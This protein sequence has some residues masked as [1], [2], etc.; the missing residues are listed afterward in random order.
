METRKR[1]V[2]WVLESGAF[3]ERP[4][5]MREAVLRAGDRWLEWQDEWLESGDWPPLRDGPVV[6]RGSLGNADV[7]R[8]RLLWA[9][10]AYCDTA[11]FH[12]SSWY[13]K[14]GQW[15]IQSRWLVLSVAELVRDPRPI[16]SALGDPNDVFVRPDSPLKAFSGRV[17]RVAD[18]SLRALDYGYYY[19]DAE[20]PVIVAPVRKIG[21]EWRY[22]VVCRNV[23]AGSAYCS[24]QRRALPDDPHGEPWRFA[25]TVAASLEAPEE[26]YVLDVCESDGE[27]YLLELNPF[28][29]ADLY[30]CD[31]NKVV[32]AV[33][34]HAEGVAKRR[35]SLVE[36]P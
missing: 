9:P 29:G 20:L 14:V 35:T 21:R 18:I 15:L 27:L 5:L 1:G 34:L 33:S 16:L 19:D 32:A 25:S 22:V 12:C 8:R 13:P 7:I 4:E 28:S 17:V 30:G 26:V 2:T 31:R 24:E 23:V 36:A 10:G 3:Q 6:F 11:A